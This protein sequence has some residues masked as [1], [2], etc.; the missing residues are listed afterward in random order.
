MEKLKWSRNNCIY[1]ANDG[2][3]FATTGSEE[4]KNNNKK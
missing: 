4:G 1:D 2:I 3:A